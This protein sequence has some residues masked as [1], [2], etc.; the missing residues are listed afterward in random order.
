MFWALNLKD[1]RG[2]CC[3]FLSDG[4]TQTTYFASDTLGR[5]PE[6]IQTLMVE[7]ESWFIWDTFDLPE[8]ANIRWQ[9][10]QQETVE[11]LIGK[12]LSL[13]RLDGEK[14]SLEAFPI[15]WHITY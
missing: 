10:C 6:N 14:T 13:D 2:F 11:H 15:T 9:N 8:Y 7:H 12:P 4:T 5:K 3:V 1:K